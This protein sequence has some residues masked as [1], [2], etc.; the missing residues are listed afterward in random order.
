MAQLERSSGPGG[1]EE[2]VEILMPVLSQ[3]Y[4]QAADTHPWLLLTNTHSQGAVWPVLHS[5]VVPLYIN[6]MLLKKKN[7]FF[8]GKRELTNLV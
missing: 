4:L 5:A 2:Q 1:F 6:D 8:G 7:N 3:W